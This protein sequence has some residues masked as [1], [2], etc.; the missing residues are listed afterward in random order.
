MEQW[1]EWARGPVFKFA[2]LLMVL[3][4]A[5]NVV[6]E[7]VEIILAI[8]RAGDKNIPYKVV[9]KTTIDWLI[10]FKKMGV[11][12][13]VYSVMSVVFHVG[14]ILTPIFLLPHIELWERGLGIAWPSIPHALADALTLVTIAAAIGLLAGRLSNR[15]S[16]RISRVQDLVIPAM[17]VIPFITGFFAMHPAWNPAD[18]NLVMFIHVMSANVIFVMIPFSKL[19]HI[20]LL[21]ATQ[22]VSEVGW[23]F[24]AESGDDVAR[25]LK[26]ENVPI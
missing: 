10:P 19:G 11:N 13:P 6:V 18:Y 2:F 17:L 22:L 4:L 20:V 8:R 5:R 15:E 26:K 7:A 12:R 1:L 21:P 9:F 24:P 23:R 25:A 16:R 14:L 3:A